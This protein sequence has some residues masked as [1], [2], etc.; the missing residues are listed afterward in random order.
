MGSPERFLDSKEVSAEIR[1]T[2]WGAR[3]TFGVY[4]DFY[5]KTGRNL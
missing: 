3:I 4:I 2:W 1:E 5:I